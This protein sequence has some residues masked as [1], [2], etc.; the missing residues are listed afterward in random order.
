MK[1]VIGG[2][3]SGS[4]GVAILR[5]ARRMV[6]GM[7]GLMLVSACG[8]GV[9]DLRVAEVVGTWTS[10]DGGTFGF[11]PDGTFVASGVLA[12]AVDSDAR[13]RVSGDGTWTIAPNLYAPNGPK[14]EVHLVFFHRTD[15]PAC[16]GKSSSYLIADFDGKS[17]VLFYYL[18]DPDLNIQYRFAR[19]DTAVASP[20]LHFD[21]GGRCPSDAPSPSSISSPTV[22]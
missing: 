21:R 20:G 16:D 22:A 2:A 5:W 13:Q 6:Y 17:P 12:E 3:L 9:R 11:A 15:R 4:S 7:L 18:D 19:V 10:A 1:I 14:S 8:G